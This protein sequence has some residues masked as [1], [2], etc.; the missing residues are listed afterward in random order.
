[1][2]LNPHHEPLSV[3]QNIDPVSN[4]LEP[5]IEEPVGPN[6]NLLPLD[7]NIEPVI[8]WLPINVFEPVVAWSKTELLTAKNELD[9]EAILAL[10][11]LLTVIILALN[12]ADEIR[13]DPDKSYKLALNEADATLYELDRS[14]ILALNELDAIVYEPDRSYRLALNEAEAKVYDLDT[15]NKLELNDADA[16]TYELETAASEPLTVVILLANELLNVVVDV[17]IL[18]LNDAV[19]AYTC[20]SVA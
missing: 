18:A 2:P 10:S 13:Y 19:C 12:D 17:E 8:V 11:E 4:D 15:A 20:A 3:F 5:V 16:I 1:M 6:T 9:N 7:N 14:E